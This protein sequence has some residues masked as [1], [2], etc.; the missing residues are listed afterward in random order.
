MEKFR[1]TFIIKE[2]E[3]EEKIEFKNLKKGDEFILFDKPNKKER[4][5]GDLSWIAD[6]DAKIKKDEDY[7][8]IICHVKEK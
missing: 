4:V 3:T 1:E 8:G 6:E 7:Y 2:D 5:A